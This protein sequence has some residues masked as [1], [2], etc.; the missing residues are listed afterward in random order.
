MVT[1]TGFY[2]ICYTE[3][4]EKALKAEHFPWTHKNMY[5]IL[6]YKEIST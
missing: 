1:G 6:R 2:E 5:E 3:V 4:E